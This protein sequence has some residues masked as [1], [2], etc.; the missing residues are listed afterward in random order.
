MTVILLTPYCCPALH[1]EGCDPILSSSSPSPSSPPPLP[2]CSRSLLCV[3]QLHSAA[4]NS[5]VVHDSF[6]VTGSDDKVLRVWPLDFSD[7]LLEV[8]GVRRGGE[9]NREREARGRGRK[10]G[11]W[12]EGM[13]MGRVVQ[14]LRSRQAPAVRTGLALL[15]FSPSNPSAHCPNPPLPNNPR[16]PPIPQT[17]HEAQVASVI[18]RRPPLSPG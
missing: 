10:W 14:V 15:Y 9:K 6:C 7:Y 4:I 1:S 5:L 16:L 18:L 3:Y 13:G 11:R 12:Q 2:P 17:V 8:R